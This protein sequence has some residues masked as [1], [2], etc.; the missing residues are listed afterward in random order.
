MAGYLLKNT[1]TENGSVAR[2][3]CGTDDAGNL[4]SIVERSAAVLGLKLE[5]AGAREIACRSRG[6]PRIANRLL[7]RVRDYADVKNNGVINREV[8]AYSLE[9]LKI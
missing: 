3:V 2:G 6:T 9:M 7:R 8:A 5:T 4:T 1:L